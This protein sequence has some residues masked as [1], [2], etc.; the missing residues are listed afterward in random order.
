MKN[1]E[2]KEANRKAL[3]KFL[4]FAV[5]C[6]IVGGVIGYYSGYGAAKGGMDELVGM[7]KE[8]GAF[9]GTHIAPWLMVAIAIIVPVLCLPI[10]RSAK[11]L[12]AAWDGEDEAISDTIDRKLS[13]V[14]WI[15]SA[16]F[17]VA[18][19]LIAASYSGG[20][21]IFD[22]MEKTIV[23]FIGIVSFFAIMIEAILFQQ[24]C[25]DTTKQMNPEKKASVYDMRFQ[26]S[27][28]TTA[29]KPKNY[30]R[31]VCVQSILRNKCG[32]YGFGDRA[33][34][35]CACVRHWIPAL[36]YCMPYLGCKYIDVL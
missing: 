22:D 15:A 6:A 10:Y 33:C 12:L 14:I 32:V 28:L 25:V 30:D 11:K 27:G 24:K 35:L 18:Y 5:V 26:K 29:M 19:F 3:P 17:I 23:F 34:G 20:F 36:I 21:A 1:D 16:S 8:T 2:I 4:L 7:M 31:Q 13:V 9:F